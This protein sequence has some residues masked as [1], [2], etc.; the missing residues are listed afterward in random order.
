[1][2]LELQAEL[3]R[4]HPMILRKAPVITEPD[5]E[6]G[7]APIDFWGAECGDGWFDL[8]DGVLSRFEEYL[9]HLKARG[10]PKNQWPRVSQIKEKFGTLRL[11]LR[12]SEDLPSE[13]IQ[14][15]EVAEKKSASICEVCGQPGMMRKDGCLTVL[16]N[17]CFEAPAKDIV[18][19]LDDWLGSLRKLLNSRPT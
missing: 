14:E 3:F 4:R 6:S 17:T 8:L 2:R 10:V 11:Y 5:D 16:C 9:D 19:N 18:P 12:T 13:L 1:M 15:I 7:E